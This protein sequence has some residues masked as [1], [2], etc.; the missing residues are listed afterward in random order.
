[1]KKDIRLSSIRLAGILLSFGIQVVLVKVV[2]AA[3]Y[4]V[5]ILF[6]TWS[7]IFSQV[8]ILGYDRF[9]IKEL[10]FL[11][12]QK[13]ISKFRYSLD[14]VIILIFLNSFIFTLLAFCTPLSFLRGTFFSSDLLLSTW[15]LIAIGS[16]FFTA[17]QL[18][19][20]IL[21]T[22]QQIELS[23]VRSEIIYKFLLLISVLVFFYF[24]RRTF[25]LNIILAGAII[26][27]FITI[28][29]FVFLDREKLI[30]YLKVKKEKVTL[31]RENYIFFFITLNYFLISQLDKI[32]LGRVAN[33]QTL[34]IY[35]LAATLCSMTGFSVVGYTRLIPK[36][37]NYINQDLMAELESEFKTVVRNAVIIALPVMMF[38]L[39][40]AEDSLLFFGEKY[41]LAAD[42]L[43]ILLIGQMF[44][45]F[46]GPNGN[47]LNNGGHAK[48]DMINSV[49]V[50]VLTAFL[51]VIGYQLYGFIGVAI[52][53]S[54][55]V[56][57]MNLLRVIQVKIF[58]KI[59]P[60]D[61]EN[62]VLTLIAFTAFISVRMFNFNP[63][64]LILK[65]GLNFIIGTVIAAILASAFYKLR[66]QNFIKLNKGKIM[67][68]LKA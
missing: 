39:V 18:I 56:T 22:I 23:Y 11:F 41:M 4:G 35:G 63:G 2:G 64:I 16:A 15:I 34:G 17:F 59:F 24:F 30:K 57:I 37:S 8:L 20:K 7:T 55:G 12:L 1:M 47:L 21:I 58:L 50:L 40:F 44:Y 62:V 42:A 38:L 3:E 28:V 27:Y 13:E 46:T 49:V 68:K 9:L 32:Q 14:K 54:I 43:R 53:T 48:I 67:G 10:S 52:A 26:S 25:G 61:I 29:L 60:Y 6:T 5:F 65:L 51:N 45:Y 31:G 66:G 36:I 19:G 33:M